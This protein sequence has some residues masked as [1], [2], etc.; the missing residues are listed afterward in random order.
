M[1][2]R[3]LSVLLSL[4]MVGTMCTAAAVPAS[5][6]EP[7]EYKKT[8][9]IMEEIDRGLIATVVTQNTANNISKGGVYLSWR[10]LGKEDLATTAYVFT[11]REQVPK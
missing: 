5:A 3:I 4:A 7:V 1:R 11:E 2:K 6:D 10:V 8:P 9:R